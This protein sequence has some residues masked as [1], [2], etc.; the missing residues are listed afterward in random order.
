MA[1]VP[2]HAASAAALQQAADAD[3][4]TETFQL[5]GARGF[6]PDAQRGRK[7]EARGLINRSAGENRLDVLSLSSVGIDCGP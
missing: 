3:L 2:E 7:I 1:V 6:R 4:G 5:A